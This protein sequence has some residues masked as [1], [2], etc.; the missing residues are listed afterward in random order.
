[1]HLTALVDRP[2]HVCCRYRL[3]AFRPFLERAG[4]SLELV[5]LPRRWWGRLWLYRRLHG[6]AV[7]LQRRLLPAWELER[8]RQSARLLL[9]D[10]DDAVFLRDSYAPRGLHSARRLQRFAAIVRA[11]DAVIAGNG[12]LASN[13]ARWAGPA[14]VH[15]IPTCVDPSAYP[16]TP[17][18]SPPRGEGSRSS[19]LSP[20]GRGVGGEGLSRQA[21]DG[22]QLVWVGSSS[23]LRGLEAVRPM[24][25]EVGRRTAGAHLKIICDRFLHFDGLPVVERRWDAAT[26]AA[27]IAAADV[28]I[29]WIPDDDWSRG[30][31][32]LKV[33]QY[34]AAGLPVVANAVGVHAEMIRHGE[35]GFLADTAEEWVDAV[36]RLARDP[37]L[38]GRMGAAGRRLLE[39]RY[40]VASGARRWTALLDELR[41]GERRAG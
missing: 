15:V 21:D 24:L 11:C 2:D 5:S 19:P 27:E 18:P 4:C 33:L 40:S 6:A 14:R 29:S 13:A 35:T 8:L 23:T 39:D 17:N 1:V 26:E 31:C 32:G 36:G 30:K 22:V 20:W 37:D 10:L 9:F 7:V 28:G 16:L 38:R 12:F 34:M 3:A 25:E 41:R